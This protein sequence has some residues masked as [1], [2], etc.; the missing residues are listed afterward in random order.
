MWARDAR[1]G[2]KAEFGEG[3]RMWAREVG[4]ERGM[5]TVDKVGMMCGRMWAKGRLWAREIACVWI[6]RTVQVI[7]T[8]GKGGRVWKAECG[9]R[10]WVREAG[11]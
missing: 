4:R 1:C 8:V 10:M 7:K 11:V 6:M 9:S 5:Q 3:D 2:R